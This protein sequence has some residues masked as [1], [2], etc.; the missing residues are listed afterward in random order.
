MVA[1]PANDMSKWC[2]LVQVTNNPNPGGGN[3][4]G[5][6]QGQNKVLHVSGQS[7]WN[8][9]GGQNIFPPP[10]GYVAGDYLVNLGAMN[11]ISYSINTT[12]QPR[13]LQLTVFNLLNTI[14]GTP[15]APV[16]NELYPHIVDLQ[17]QYG[18]DDGSNSGTAD[19][20]L[21]DGWDNVTPTTNAG[22]RRVLA[23]RVAVLARSINPEKETV[24]FNVPTWA[25]GTFNMSWDADT[26]VWGNANW[27]HYRYK[28]YETTIP[29]R[30]LIWH[31]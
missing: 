31:Q 10:D 11:D 1:V 14:A 22:W 21:V 19:D 9:P 27:G 26:S 24:T 2:T 15:A 12:V 7:E 23:I 18:K 29:I 6:G 3:N 4:Q 8:Q 13:A 5:G 30:N 28:T 25:G 17:A 20:G 16:T